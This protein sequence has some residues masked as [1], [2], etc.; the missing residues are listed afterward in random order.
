[1]VV[2]RSLS[3][4]VPCFNEEAVLKDTALR[5]SDV[6]DHLVNLGLATSES[7]I[8]F[9]DDGSDD[10]TWVLVKCLAGKSTRFHGIKLSRNHGHQNALLAGL[11]SAP[12]DV[13]ISID[14]DLQDDANAIVSMMQEH[15]AGADVVY[16]VRTSRKV[17]TW[18]KRQTAETYYNLL[19]LLGVKLV[20]NHADFR[21]LS[22]RAIDALRSYPEVNVFL[23]GIIPQLGFKSASVSY[24]RQPRFSGRSKYS[25]RKMLALAIDGVTSFSVLPLRL[26]TFL[27][28]AVSL[29]SLFVTIWALTIRLFTSYTIPGWTSTVVPIYFLGGIQLLSLGVIGEYLGKCYGETKRRPRYIIEE[30][31]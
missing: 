18:F 26:I 8:Y 24:A 28:L 25:L 31:V 30:V 3:I 20:P 6:M 11:L 22:R 29:L 16:G 17:D 10:D 23:R 9:V 2:M 1:M 12:G 5:L 13:L 7:G 15:D 21:L 14:A 19:G 4:T 27:G